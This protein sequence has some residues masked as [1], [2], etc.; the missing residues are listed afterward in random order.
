M[1]SSSSPPSN[2]KLGYYYMLFGFTLVF[3]VLLIISFIAMSC[4]TWFQR[5]FLSVRRLLNHKH[6]LKM[7][8]WIPTFKYHN[9]AGV[10]GEEEEA[11]PECVI[12]LSPFDEGE[13]VRQLSS[14]RHLFHAT[15][16]D[17]WLNV[18][19]NCLMCRGIVLLHSVN[20]ST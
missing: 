18:H 7:Q 14:C 2:G 8:C 17:L 20:M 16:I 19:S 11:A 13:D 15:C 10:G 5:Q 9:E 3:I 12:C 6:D 4:C 1:A